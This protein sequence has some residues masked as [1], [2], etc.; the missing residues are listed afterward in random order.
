MTGRIL[1]APRFNEGWIPA[2]YQVRGRPFAGMTEGL[3]ADPRLPEAGSAR[4][5]MTTGAEIGPL[6]ASLAAA[7]S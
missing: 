4:V 5:R 3:R 7:R 6:A 2:P 1:S